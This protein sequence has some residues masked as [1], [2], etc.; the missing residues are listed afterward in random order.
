MPGIMSI[1]NKSQYLPEKL[2]ALNKWCER[3]GVLAGNYEKVVLIDSK[4]A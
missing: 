2:E 4:R 3:L 1:Y